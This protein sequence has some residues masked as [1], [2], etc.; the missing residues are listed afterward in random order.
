MFNWLSCWQLTELFRSTEPGVEVNTIRLLSV[1]WQI[2]SKP[3]IS[4]LIITRWKKNT[5]LVKSWIYSG[6]VCINAESDLDMESNFIP[7]I[8]ARL[9][10]TDLKAVAYFTLLTKQAEIL[11]NI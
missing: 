6:K 8:V 5:L 2:A 3:S 10:L 4:T 7:I 9:V 11:G 1:I